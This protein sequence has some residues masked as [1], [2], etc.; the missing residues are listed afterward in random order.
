[1]GRYL[2]DIRSSVKDILRAEF[3]EGVTPE[4][5]EDELD[6]LIALTLNEIE[7]KMP[8]EVKKTTLDDSSSTAIVTTADSKEIDISEITNLIRVFKVEYRTARNPKQ[9]RNF[10]LFGDTL[11][12]VI[13]FLPSADEAVHLY[14]HKKHTLTNA[15]STLKPDHEDVL[16]QGVVASAAINQGRELINSL[17]VGGGNVGPRMADWGKTQ[18]TL[19]RERLRRGAIVLAE[20]TLPRD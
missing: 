19:Y 10:T 7:L 17:N 16:I 1:M 9:F 14:C 4:W 12:M 5:E 11:T 8:Y 18:L 3:E 6:R 13:N 20:E 2:S 15:T